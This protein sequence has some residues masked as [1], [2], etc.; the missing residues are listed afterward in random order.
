MVNTTMIKVGIVAGEASGDLLGSQLIEA[1][2]RKHPNIQF[3]GIAGPKMQSLGAKS[4]FPMERLSIRGYIEVIKHLRGLMKL[5]KQLFKTLLKEKIDIF[6]GVDA[7]D[8]NFWLEKKLKNK[9]IKTVH[10]VS[11]S[12]WAWRK[13]RIHK[14]KKCVDHMLALFPFE[15]SYYQAVGIPVTFVGH[16]L[17][18]I[19]PFEPNTSAARKKLDISDKPLVVAMLPGSRLSEVEQHARLFAQVAAR[20]FTK[21]PEVQFLVPFITR[22]TRSIFEQAVY[23]VNTVLKTKALPIKLLFGHAHDAMEAASVVV[24]ASGTATLEA[25]LLKK[26]MVITYK[27]PTLSWEI[28][29]RKRLQPY[30]GL[31]NI[32]AARFVVPE[33]LQHDATP[34]NIAAEVLKMAGDTAYAQSIKDEFLTIH[35]SLKNDSANKAADVILELALTKTT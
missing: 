32:L 24:V 34:Q 14:I 6:V 9:G 27:M 12:I 11:P 10:Y 4:L 26:P 25:A 18:E 20:I 2:K 15:P 17:A 33:L 28:L 19:I 21:Q 16:P 35:K 13:N 1:L 3:I 22:D 8:F 7:P 5:R 31:P 29:K 30:V 23:D